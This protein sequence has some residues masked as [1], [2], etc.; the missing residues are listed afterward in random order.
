MA[1]DTLDFPGAAGVE[2]DK[3][4][5]PRWM[6]WVG[7]FSGI[8]LGIVLL[9]SVYAKGLDPQGFALGIEKM[10][11]IPA[12]L[13]WL[14]AVV[15]LAL[16]AGLGLALVLG[17]RTRWTL[18]PTTLLI[19]WFLVLLTKEF[20]L[21]TPEASSCGCFG[22]L[23]QRSP[24]EALAEDAVLLVLAL[25][26]WLGRPREI[27]MRWRYFLA[28]AAAVGTIALAII[29][30]ALP[31]DDLATRLKPGVKVGALKI[32]EILPE[33]QSGMHLVVLLDRT[34]QQTRA[35]IG[36]LNQNLA[37]TGGPVTV[38]GLVVDEGEK[39][40]ELATEFQWTAAPGFEVRS[41][42]YAAIK[43]LYRTLPRTFLVKDGKVLKTWTR[44]PE[45]AVLSL[46]AEGKTP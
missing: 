35:E 44:I 11:V 4:Q 18:I 7:L 28:G 8:L 16:E 23:V 40:S 26:A 39:E 32:D 38:F 46:L 25:A 9:V 6:R 3:P 17:L 19:T 41:G 29:A 27:R 1:E 13:E 10:K 2:M 31:V 45:D 20:F 37:L 21:P 14:A 5:S 42:P 22:N 36:R 33:L 34:D 12:G 15:T 43:P 24:G 30:P